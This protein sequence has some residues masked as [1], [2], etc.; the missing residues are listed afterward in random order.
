MIQ[1]E[2]FPHTSFIKRAINEDVHTCKKC[3]ETLPIEHFNVNRRNKGNHDHRCKKCLSAYQKGLSSVKKTARLQGKKNPS[4]CEICG[5]SA[6]EQR[7]VLDHCHD[8]L[9]HRGWLCPLCSMYSANMV[10]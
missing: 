1:D 6:N 3:G 7:I 10:S 8:T 9:K 5:V 2:L 4:H